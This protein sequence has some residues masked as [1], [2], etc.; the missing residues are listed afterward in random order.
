MAIDMQAKLA[1]LR[2]KKAA[3][4]ASKIIQ[5]KSN[6][7]INKLPE[8]ET[9]VIS[10]LPSVPSNPATVLSNSVSAVH[11]NTTV[12]NS[13]STSAGTFAPAVLGTAKTSEID[14]LD[15]LSKL[16][17]LQDAMTTQH[18]TMPVLLMQIHKQLMADPELVTVL[19]EEAIGLIVRGLQVQTKTELVQVSLKAA[20]TTR[21]KKV[22]LSVDMF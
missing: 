17:S 3:E 13:V 18:P 20:S 10:G 15:F 1:E 14:H 8:K 2:A 4:A 9:P 16:N 22:Q 11:N 21:S 12:P 6:E 7:T 5:D 19:N